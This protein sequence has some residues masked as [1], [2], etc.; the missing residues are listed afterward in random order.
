[1]FFMK[2]AS[3]GSPSGG[4]VDESGP[5]VVSIDPGDSL[6]TKKQPIII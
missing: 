4:P 6:I 2:C 5:I 3:Q 1:M